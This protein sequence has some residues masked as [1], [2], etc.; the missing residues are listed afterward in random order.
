MVVANEGVVEDSDPLAN[1]G[2]TVVLGRCSA[3]Q[4]SDA[5]SPVVADEVSVDRDD[6]VRVGEIVDDLD[7]VASGPPDFVASEDD[8]RSARDRVIVEA[9]LHPVTIAADHLVVLDEQVANRMV[10]V[11]PIVECALEH[12]P[13]CGAAAPDLVVELIVIRDEEVADDR[14]R[15]LQR[16]SGQAVAENQ[17]GHGGCRRHARGDRDHIERRRCLEDSRVARRDGAGRPAA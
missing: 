5:R 4:Q 9:H 12:V 16:H 10:D 6:P 3:I 11:D 14:R 17:S 15:A 13:P 7:S 8:V 2:R 1:A